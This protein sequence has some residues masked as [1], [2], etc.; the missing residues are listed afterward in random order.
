LRST[1]IA[2]A[3][4]LEPLWSIHNPANVRGVK[5][6]L[7]HTSFGTTDKYYIMSQ[8][9]VAGRALARAIGSA[10]NFFLDQ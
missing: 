7:G 5:D 8:S 2:S 10:T 1:Y 6:L 3:T 9:R 4:P